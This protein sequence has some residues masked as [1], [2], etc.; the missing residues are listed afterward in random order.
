MSRLR[1]LLLED[2]P[3]DMAALQTTLTG[4][5]LDYALLTV[6]TS[7]D[8][9][10]ALE[11]QTFDLI[12][13]AYAVLDLAGIAALEIAVNLCPD[14][15]FIF[16]SASLGEELAIETLKRGATDYVLKQRLE[17]L[18][19]C[20]HRA[21]RETQERQAHKQAEQLL[22]E[23]KQLLELIAFGRSLDDCL[24]AI[25]GAITRLN[26]HVRAS[27]LLAD[28]QR[29]TFPRSIAAGFPPS[30]EQKLKDLPINDLCIGTC[31]EAV[32]RG[33]PIT[34]ADIA[35]DDRWSQEWRDLCIAHGILACHSTPVLGVDG[36]P[37]GSLMLCFEET[38]TP[39]DWE[40][41]LAEFGVQV[42]S[43][44]FERDRAQLALRESE[45]KYR[46]LFESM[47]QGF[48]FCEMQF[49]PQGA[50]IDYRFL[51]VNPVFGMMTGLQEAVGKTARELVPDLEVHWFETYGKVV[52]TGESIRF[53]Q[54]SAAMN[55][56]FE[57]SAFP[58]GEPQSYQF[59][60]LFTDISDRKQ[61][62]AAL[63]ASEELTQSILES[64]RDCI[65][66]LMLDSSISYISPGG[67]CLLEIDDPTTIV[68]TIWADQWQGE[69]YAK[70]KAAIAAATLGNIGQFQ[71]YFPTVKG[72]PKWWDSMI[73]PVRDATGQVVQLVVISRD[74]TAA[75]QIEVALRESEE[76]SRNILESTTD[77]FFAV[78]QDWRFTYVNQTAEAL[79]DR[80]AADLLGKVFWEEF[81]GVNNS[82][83]EQMHRRVMRDRMAE[84][85]TE[86]YPDHD[87][88]YEVRS[89]P[90]VNG[91]TIYFR[92]VT[93]QIQAEE[94]L[95]ESEERF[96]TLADQ[97]SQFAWMA[98]ASGWIFWYNCRWFE[99]TGT[100]L[101]QMQGW[102]WQQVHHP[103]HVDRV[104]E[105]F[106]Y[107]LEVGEQWEDTFPLRSK[108]GSYGWFLSRAI[109][110]RDAAGNILRWFGTNTDI[111]ERLQA[112]Q[113][114]EQLLERERVARAEAE[115]ANRIKDEF[116]AV[117]SHELRSPLNPILGWS[118]L[119]QNG[120]FNEARRSDALKTI[121]R[122]A[123]LQSQ[124]IED[125]LDISRIMQGKLALTATPVSLTFVISAAVETV[126]LAAAAKN[127]GL[128]LDLD[129]TAPV[130]GDATRLQ[131]VVWNLLTNAVKFTPDGGQVTVELRQLDRLAQLRVIDT[132]KGIQ[133]Q[134][135]PH[136]FEYFRQEDG[137]TT[138]KFGG[139]GLGLAI[140]RQI[141][142]MH[143]GTVGVES[144]GEDQGATFIVHLP[145][146][147]QATAIVSEPSRTLAAT[148]MP[149]GN[150]QI[151]LVDD[152]RDTREFQAFLLQQKG[153]KVI[154]VA[155]GLAALQALE[156]LSPDL[157]VSDVGMADMNGYQLMQQ[158]RSRPAA[159]SGTIPAIALTA[160]AAEIDQQ[161]SL[162]A[163]FQ[164][165]L[166]KP[167]EPD[168]LVQAI[169]G[170][171]D[172]R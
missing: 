99:Y 135:L 1:F 136:V 76:Q 109:P 12:L 71:G 159:Q 51:E 67:L 65:K 73:T 33:Q 10:A 165:H 36:L 49:D 116:L 57:V 100:T 156:Q 141:V 106:R 19:P 18:V 117:L 55:R 22:L 110:V 86:F 144:Q 41:Q 124:L 27:F 45:A 164:T 166:T 77:A 158:I 8:F 85:L 25:C 161:Q 59:A 17:R 119:L 30:F 138:R 47:D 122:N 97:M 28:A 84:S 153:A 42:A 149:L 4:S 72:T 129:P 101:E 56:W 170:L 54:Q 102:S 26:P 114:R 43:V 81:P 3:L 53:E 167:V 92:N 95:R 145:V 29:L 83:F 94:V 137:S 103:E 93:H 126:Q 148:E 146:M 66:V 78:D 105:H 108:D 35:N 24:T 69:D 112:E 155:S 118:R 14:V 58:V 2:K 128:Q 88:W 46:R 48:C 150:L 52:R 87:R 147:Q 104:V 151:L 133:P 6:S 90:A 125:L 37:L 111:T 127:I 162:Q 96:R 15:P 20:V 44:G 152:D 120:N 115:Q 169:V 130:S 113:E 142:E 5:G 131:Q 23:Q 143:G 38:R 121:E 7:V 34:C 139:L 132:G 160:Y 11:T 154:A 60:I 98:D 16:V 89:Y 62:E 123:K 61:S 171:L 68:N 40:Y 80:T 91:I 21:L 9:V 31:S 168:G 82:A 172:R 75:R 79:V 63:R 134:F 140:V 32:Y 74:I 163:G 50:P 39:I 107:C 157:I 70:A 13:A 64:S